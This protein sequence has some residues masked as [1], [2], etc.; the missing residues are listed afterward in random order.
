[1]S[2]DPPGSAAAAALRGHVA[3][4]QALAG[5]LRDQALAPERAASMVEEA[6]AAAAAA[7]GELERLA[8]EAATGA[9]TGYVP[10]GQDR[11]L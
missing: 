9:T 7:S 4:L 1:M 6:A 10:P 2:D 8:R 3:R 5:G 11:L